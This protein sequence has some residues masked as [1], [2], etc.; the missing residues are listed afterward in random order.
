MQ[1]FD[2]LCDSLA[3]THFSP[4][5]KAGMM[6]DMCKLKT[7]FQVSSNVRKLIMPQY[8]NPAIMELLLNLKT[9]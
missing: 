7:L 6:K 1:A 5:E 2:H 8:R 4:S 3:H 9:E